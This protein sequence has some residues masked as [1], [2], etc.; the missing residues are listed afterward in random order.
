MAALAIKGHSTKGE[1]IIKIL[2][3]L[4]AENYYK[5]NG[6]SE[7]T[8]YYID[9]DNKIECNYNV[10][11]HFPCVYFTLEEF[12]EKYPYKIGN[13]VLYK[14]D[15][16]TYFIRKMFWENDK[17]LYELSDEVYSDGCSIPDT[18]IV[19]VDVVKLQLHKKETMEDRPN[20]LQQLKEYF[21]NTPREVVEKEWHEYDKYNEIG[22]S[23][24]EYLEYINNI[25]Q[26]QYPKNYEECCK[27]LNIPSNG[28]IAYVGNWVYGGEYLE[29]HLDRLRKF[30]QLL[31]CRDAYWKIAGEQMGLGKPWEPDWSTEYE[32]K[33][34]IEVYRNKVRTNSQGYSNTILAFPTAEMCDAF[35]EN[36]K[37]LIEQCKELL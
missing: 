37:N 6:A 19:G 21:K 23:V 3:M 30:Q 28:N 35:Y 15:N 14:Y 13:K 32:T 18:L 7:W 5:Y 27:I 11:I 26:P 9:K 33:Y 4:G 17:I 31:I 2:E 34:V 1:K 20:L 22:P 29:K 10:E 8:Y 12:L 25:R 16:K 36:F 24:E